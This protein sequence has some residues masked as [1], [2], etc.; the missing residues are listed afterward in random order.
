MH[1]K[2]KQAESGGEAPDINFGI[3]NIV[4]GSSFRKKRSLMWRQG[5]GSSRKSA[6]LRFVAAGGGFQ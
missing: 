5:I 4:S 2:Q 1:A 6:T 3:H